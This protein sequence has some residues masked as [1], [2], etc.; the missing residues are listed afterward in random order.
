MLKISVFIPCYNEGDTL[1]KS[2]IKLYDHLTQSKYSFELFIIDDASSDSTPLIGKKLS[3]KHKQIR[4]IRYDS[5]PSRRENLA[6]SFKLAKG[7]IIL[8]M[9]ADLATNLN[10]F[11]SLVKETEKY[12]IVTGS[13]HLPKSIVE[14]TFYRNLISI[15]FKY[16]VMF[17]FNSKI[18]DHQCGFKAFK[19]EVI[20]ELVEEMGYDKEYKRK[21]FWDSEMLIRA[22][23]KYKIKEIPV[24]W[25]AAE[26]STMKF[27]KEL[28]MFPYI[29]KLRFKL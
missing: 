14:R 22:Q 15:L 5:G 26:K 8:F 6:Q 24:H 23:K 20:L 4:F 17:Y 7:D 11:Q 10:S 19:K 28:S 2:I 25:K 27:F 1:K 13:R 3:K 12:D 21:M 9:D 18:Y 16:F 29:L